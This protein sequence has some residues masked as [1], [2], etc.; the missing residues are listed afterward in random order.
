MT[1]V[2]IYNSGI[3][4]EARLYGYYAG[5]GAKIYCFNSSL[6]EIVCYGTSCINLT[7]N[8][9]ESST[10]STIGT[11]TYYSDSNSPEYYRDL[12][13]MIPNTKSSL[14]NNDSIVCVTD[15][16]CDDETIAIM[17]WS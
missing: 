6:C 15:S 5:Y 3:N 10:C 11:Q 16:S 14:A 8:C 9:D 7:L 2:T 12:S 17:W 13:V 1:N 4:M